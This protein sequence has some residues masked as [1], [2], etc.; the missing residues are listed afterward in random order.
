MKLIELT[1][2]SSRCPA[3]WDGRREDGCPVYIRFRH[4]VL[5]VE[6]GPPKTN[7]IECGHDWDLWFEADGLGGFDDE[8]PIE[9]VCGLARLTLAEDL[10]PFT[11]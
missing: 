10:R 11:P 9:Q 6:I 7:Y 8:M 1:Q 2:T 4:G 3:Q 5:S